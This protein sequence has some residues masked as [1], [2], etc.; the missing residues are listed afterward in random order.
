MRIVICNTPPSMAAG[1]AR[2]LVQ[3]RL[4]AC[5]NIVPSVQSIYV[6]DAEVCEET[7]STLVIKVAAERVDSLRERLIEIHPYDVP[8]FV[9]MNVDTTASHGPYVDWVRTQG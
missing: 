9:V 2:S 4:A 1:I 8:E 5:V 7:E 6:W 3:E